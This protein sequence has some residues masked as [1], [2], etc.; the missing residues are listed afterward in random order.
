MDLNELHFRHQI[1]LMRG[2][3]TTSASRRAHHAASAAGLA[4]RIGVIQR[5]GGALAAP[6]AARGIA[7]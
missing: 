1:A 2:A 6:L 7:A 3:G 4:A 5:R